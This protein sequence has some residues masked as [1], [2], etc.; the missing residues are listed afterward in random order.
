MPSKEVE[1][2]VF[3]FVY[4]GRSK[5]SV[6]PSERPDFIVQHEDGHRF[7]VE[8]TEC[9]SSE[10][11]AR[12][13][14]RKGYLDELIAGGSVRH[15]DDRRVLKVTNID[16]LWRNGIKRNVGV[17]AI[18][19]RNPSVAEFTRTVAEKVDR[20]AS[21][22]SDSRD[23]LSHVNLIIHDRTFSL[24]ELR[25]V[26]DFVAICSSL[27]S[28]LR[29]AVAQSQF[30]EVFLVTKLE[31]VPGFLPLK[32]LLLVSELHHFGMFASNSDQLKAVPEDVD[33]LEVFAS[34]LQGNVA[35]L[36]VR[37]EE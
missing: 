35:R 29:I 7:G 13:E 2:R 22:A 17:P 32:T 14:Y 4:G 26:E 6:T 21:I 20:K 19:E 25:A 24:T 31:G 18:E 37:L 28:E 5:I 12:L 15:K 23:R 3:A 16:Y 8:V 1:R 30:R 10:S 27:A 33:R 34:Y 36:G 11:R 9:F